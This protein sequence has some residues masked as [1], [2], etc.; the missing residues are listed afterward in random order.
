MGVFN[1]NVHYDVCFSYN[2]DAENEDEARSIAERM[3]ESADTCEA[4]W[5]FTETNSY[6]YD[7]DEAESVEVDN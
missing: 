4:E 2:I 7:E 5:D 1:V 6:E 3:S